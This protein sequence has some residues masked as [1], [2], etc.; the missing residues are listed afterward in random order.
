M[1]SRR[2]I[3]TL[4]L[5]SVLALALTLASQRFAWA[6]AASV[7]A[8]FVT[9]LQDCN[10]QARNPAICIHAGQLGCERREA[11]DTA[12][13]MRAQ[14]DWARPEVN[15]ARVVFL[16]VLLGLLQGEAVLP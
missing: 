5:F 6:D 7:R 8:C 15:T 16:G 3:S 1:Y 10:E 14:S 12:D 4:L 11:E 2:N 13:V 9:V